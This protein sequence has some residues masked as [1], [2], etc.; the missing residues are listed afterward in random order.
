MAAPAA[1]M[2]D[3]ALEYARCG[4]PVFPIWHAAGDRC[5]CR[6]STCQSPG[7]HP[8][9][10]C[11]PHGFE[12]AST[13]PSTI[14][15]WWTTFPPANIAT[16]TGIT[17]TVLDVDPAKGGRDA[18]ARLEVRYGPLPATAR[19]LTGGGGDH[20]HFLPVPG[21]GN[22]AGKVGPGLDIRSV[23]G[24]VLL[25]PSNH[26]LGLYRDDPDA[27]LYETPLAVMPE[28]LIALAVGPS[29]EENRNGH[30]RGPDYWAERLIGAPEG[31]RRAVALEIAG[32]YLGLGIAAEEVQAILVG[33]AV[34]CSPPF[35]EGEARELVRDLSRRDRARGG[36]RVSDARPNPWALAVSAPDFL[37]TA[38]IEVDFLE[39]KLLAPGS[40]T[41][42]SAPRGLGKTLIAHSLL[43]KH[44]L[45]GKRGLLIDRDNSR[46]E[47]KQRVKA[48][49]GDRAPGLKVLT[50][51]N[52]PALTDREAWAMF[53]F[54]EY[55]LVVIDSI[56]AATEGVGE[57][58]SAKP[59]KALASILDIA[60]REAGP[61]I[62]VLGNTIKSAAHSRGSGVVE[63]RADIC[64]EV[65]DATD[66]KPSGQKDWWHELAPAGVDAWAL[67]ASRRKRRET[68]RLA[69]IASKFR[70]GEE[71]APFCLEVDLR[72]MPW[73]LRD[74]TAELIASGEAAVVEAKRA[75]AAAILETTEKFITFIE[76]TEKPVTTE[77]G[78]AFLIDLGLKRKAARNL[79]AEGE[80]RLWKREQLPGKGSPRVFRRCPPGGISHHSAA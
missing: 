35:S 29:S 68:F 32:H 66:L 3:A 2:L 27:P 50:R 78:E 42:W 40:I 74:V 53:P 45:A 62:L 75:K 77:E 16:R 51:E 48:W 67:R 4:D 58:D 46:R 44:A 34:R 5:G 22:S 69:F 23:G 14:R 60:H 52:A 39:D 61:A 63:D 8:I 31:E 72:A 1:M 38:E 43:V 80:G 15:Q 10:S 65:R 30:R 59:S 55:D 26:V 57:G 18:L 49:G 21:L 28:W 13:D 9:A 36:Q 12:D 7:K 33:Y 54:G 11:A 24:Y 37:N 79:L 41:Q 76:T 70:I 47:V 64:Y 6:A 17:R 71:P 25:P 20:H 56:D 73:T 19:V